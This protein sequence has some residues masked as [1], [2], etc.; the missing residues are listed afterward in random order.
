[1]AQR[2]RSL[3]AVLFDVDGTLIDSE[4]HGHRVAFNAAFED[5]GLPYRWDEDLYGKLLE[6]TGGRERL[7]LYLGGQGVDESDIP[8]LAG[9]LHEE[10]NRCFLDLV[11]RGAIP[12]RAGAKRLLYEL[13]D[14]GLRL[15]VIT[16]GSREWVETV[17]EQH[18]G[19]DRFE[20]VIAGEDVPE[21]KPDPSAYQIGLARLGLDAST[22]LAV[23]DS[24]NGLQASK[25]A[26]L[27][28]IVVANDYTKEEDLSSGDLVLDG[29]G[30]EGSPARVISN[31]HS[32]EF[33]GI[34]D[35][36][37]MARVHTLATAGAIG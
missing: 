19:L 37:L 9:A 5:A 32:V 11:A 3:Q 6:I 2:S 15:A 1:M 14:L 34:L 18:F 7:S 20:V 33:G 35:A 10:K 28:C 4:R 12:A 13:G 31:P 23:E 22:T 25:A 26:S 30:E 17:L 27:G 24:R 16:T 8:A 36:P 29:F 21:K